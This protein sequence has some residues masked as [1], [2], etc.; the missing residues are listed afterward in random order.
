M[1]QYRVS[2]AQVIA[3][4]LRGYN[5]QDRLD[6]TDG[7]TKYR[8]TGQNGLVAFLPLGA[9]LDGLHD[10]GVVHR[11]IKS[12]NMYYDDRIGEMKLGDLD[13][14][15]EIDKITEPFGTPIFPRY[16]FYG[17]TYTAEKLLRELAVKQDQ[18]C[19]LFTMIICYLGDRLNDN[20]LNW[21]DFYRAK[22]QG[23]LFENFFREFVNACIPEK[24]RGV[25]FNFLMDPIG[26][27]LPDPINKV[28]AGVVGP[29]EQILS[30]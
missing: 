26:R 16:A 24:H 21:E 11:D 22:F 4:N 13:D 23:S 30:I 6:S 20:S 2:E 8:L 5:L 1:Q 15:S 19:Y 12:Q 10:K 14:M 25:V 9:E 7:K 29:L 27:C 3:E 28:G 18:Y 17:D